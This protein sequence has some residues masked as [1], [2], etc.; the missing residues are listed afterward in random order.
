MNRNKLLVIAVLALVGAGLGIASA[1]LM[2]PQS[3]VEDTVLYSAE[4]HNNGTDIG[5]VSIYAASGYGFDNG[6]EIEIEQSRELTA[7]ERQKAIDIALSDSKVKDLLDGR[8]YEIDYVELNGLD[9]YALVEIHFP[10][11]SEGDLWYL[12]VLVNLDKKTVV[13]VLPEGMDEFVLPPDKPLTPEEEKQAINIAL[14]DPN[15]KELL[16]GR[17]YNVSGACSIHTMPEEDRYAFV[18][19]YIPSGSANMGACMMLEVNLN[20]SIV[21]Y[22]SFEMF[23][24]DDYWRSMYGDAE[25]VDCGVNSASAEA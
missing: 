1:Q 16:E 2:A 21:E 8:E 13:D 10:N 24:T 14:S 12:S 25:W 23:R 5:M 11:A 3:P 20:E 7:E 22:L 17:E 9:T 15:V 18:D 4:A 6:I 19:I